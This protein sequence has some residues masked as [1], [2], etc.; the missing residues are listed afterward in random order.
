MFQVQVHRDQRMIASRWRGHIRQGGVLIYVSNIV[1]KSCAII[2]PVN[3]G[4]FVV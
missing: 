1:C 3:S 2:G 4:G